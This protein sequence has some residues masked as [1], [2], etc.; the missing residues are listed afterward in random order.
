ME[1]AK[2]LVQG[3]KSVKLAERAQHVRI[4]AKDGKALAHVLGKYLVVPSRQAAGIE[5]VLGNV[6][7]NDRGWRF[8]PLE[9]QDKTRA[10][11]KALAAKYAAKGKVA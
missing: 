2:E 7:V 6:E 3:L 5:D 9:E 4:E 10:V 1:A 11:V 8:V